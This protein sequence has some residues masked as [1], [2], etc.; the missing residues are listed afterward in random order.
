LVLPL[1]WFVGID[2]TW[3]NS[4]SDPPPDPNA[5]L[6]ADNRFLHSSFMAAS[7]N[8]RAE[9]HRLLIASFRSQGFSSEHVLKI[10]PSASN[11]FW[12]GG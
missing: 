4:E 12:A 1:P 11:V 8:R 3:L 7:G 6:R 9:E 10:S 2:R 5:F